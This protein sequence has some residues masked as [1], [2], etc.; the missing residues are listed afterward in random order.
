MVGSANRGDVAG[1]M[2]DGQQE[3]Q[4]QNSP[5]V[6]IGLLRRIK[7]SYRFGSSCD[8]S[9]H[10]YALDI[11]L[12]ITLLCVFLAIPYTL[13]PNDTNKSGGV[14]GCDVGEV[15]FGRDRCGR[16]C[17]GGSGG[18]MVGGGAEGLFIL[19]NGRSGAGDR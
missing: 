6:L 3:P 9:T 15:V 16:S 14:G 13:F 18:F 17:V 7:V 4:L 5:P 2:E 11:V 1:R 12:A 8:C 10:A 19:G